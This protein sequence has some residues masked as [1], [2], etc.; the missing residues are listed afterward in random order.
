MRLRRFKSL[1]SHATAAIV[2]KSL[3]ATDD[4]WPK[5]GHQGLRC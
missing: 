2:D 5:R 3:M 1:K 4:C